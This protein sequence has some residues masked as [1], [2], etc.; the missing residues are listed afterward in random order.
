MTGWQEVLHAVPQKLVVQLI[1]D[2]F[3]AFF[4]QRLHP[5]RLDAPERE[6]YWKTGTSR[7]ARG[8]RLFIDLLRRSRRLGLVR[9]ENFRGHEPLI[10]PKMSTLPDSGAAQNATEVRS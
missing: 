2:P 6:K 1:Q 10:L 8:G 4:I 7:N 9:F 5:N 3:A